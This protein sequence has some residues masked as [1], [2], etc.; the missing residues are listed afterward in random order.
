MSKKWVVDAIPPSR[1]RGRHGSTILVDRRNAIAVAICPAPA[2]TG[3]V[4]MD[5]PRPQGHQLSADSLSCSI[6]VIVELDVL[7]QLSELGSIT[8]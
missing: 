2:E 3:G 7:Q 8:F 1:K 4:D 5:Y 6:A